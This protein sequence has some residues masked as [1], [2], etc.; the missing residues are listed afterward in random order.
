MKK[1]IAASA[2]LL[3]VG[4]AVAASAE[5]TFTGDA[6][7]RLI[8]ERNYDF[9]T[10]GQ[11]NDSNTGR[12][13]IVINAVTKGGAYANLRLRFVD[14]TY[15]GTVLSGKSGAAG[16]TDYYTDWAYLGIP[17]GP[18]TINAGLMPDITTLWFRYDKRFDRVAVTYANK[19]TSVTGTFDKMN[20]S[21]IDHNGQ[22]T[23]V[24]TNDLDVNQ[25]DLVVKQKFAGNWE[26]LAAGI[27]QDNQRADWNALQSGSGFQGTAQVKGPAGPVK[28]LG[29]LSFR[30]QDVNETYLDSNYNTRV[31]DG[32]GGIFHAQMDFGP[33]TG[34]FI[35]GFTKNGFVADSN[36]GFLMI[37]GA[38]AG[39]PRDGVDYGV[40]GSPIQLIPAI[41]S[42]KVGSTTVASDTFF[43][44]VVGNY[45]ISNTI[46]L[47]GDIAYA[48]M[49]NIGSALEL[50]GLVRFDVTEGAYIAVGAGM[51]SAS[52][53][54]TVKNIGYKDDTAYGAF[55][56]LGIKF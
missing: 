48:N 32:Y 14:T 40:I 47:V 8:L 44:G 4:S 36:Y 43:T 17:I 6:R 19:M 10:W 18:V 51:M 12:V 37:G 35:A 34:T 9:G 16:G 5:V 15:D 24:P 52:A 2:A 11:Q 20:E 27:Y 13:R 28:L 25:W 31:G 3:L 1:L 50:A 54:R 22:Y 26:L 53:D 23:V 33:A 21:L 41:G 38:M 46:R 39:D 29:E 30:A 45:K 56:E 7:E 55:T 42:I 49:D